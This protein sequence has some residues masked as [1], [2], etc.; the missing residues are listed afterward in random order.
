MAELNVKSRQSGNATILDLSGKITINEGAH[1]LRHTVRSTLEE[2]KKNL[3]LHLADITYVD[4]SGLG[5]LISSYT[6]TTNQGGKL[7]LLNPSQ[8][9]M[10]LLMITKLI[11]VFQVYDTEQEAVS[12][13]N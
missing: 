4:S 13:F 5:E 2:G 3:V 11:T 10:D 1:V 7:C 12:S 9:I 6:T 8:K